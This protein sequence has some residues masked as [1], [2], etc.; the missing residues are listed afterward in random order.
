MAH[1]G[2]LSAAEVAAYTSNGTRPAPPQHLLRRSKLSALLED[3][4]RQTAAADHLRGRAADLYSPG[5]GVLPR[6]DDG[7][8]ASWAATGEVCR[9]AHQSRDSRG[10]PIAGANWRGAR[11]ASEVEVGRLDNS[12]AEADRFA[13]YRMLLLPLETV[14]QNV[15]R[16]PEGDALYH[17]L[18]VFELA[19]NALPYDEEFQ[20]AALLHDVGKAIDPRDHI[21][22]ALE[23]LDGHITPRT[24][25]FIEYHAAAAALREGTL[26]V[27][28]RRRL[29]ASEDFDE[30]MLLRDCD[31]QGRLR[32]VSAPD[33]DDALE[34]LREC[35]AKMIRRATATRCRRIA[36]A[37]SQ[38]RSPLESGTHFSSV[39]ID[40]SRK[41]GRAWLCCR[42]TSRPSSC[43]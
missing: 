8:P 28:A 10:N 7:G 26:G 43:D 38:A 39:V 16:H 35:C 29:E 36:I 41:S 18:Q 20:I 33:I 5:V 2:P 25:W 9:F 31:L 21:P 14:Q 27:R 22:A 3:E 34:H 42:L 32:G 30:L 40:L 11:T 24:A 1:H 13:V 17:S 37:T 12:N 15:D 23:A 6:Q 19:R 4:Q